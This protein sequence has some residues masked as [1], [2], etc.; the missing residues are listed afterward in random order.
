MLRSL[1]LCALLLPEM[2]FCDDFSAF[3]RGFG[4]FVALSAPHVGVVEKNALSVGI[5]RGCEGR[6]DV[7]SYFAAICFHETTLKVRKYH[8]VPQGTDYAGGHYR[9]IFA[10]LQR[11]GHLDGR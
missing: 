2:A 5:W 6:L 3:Q 4:D 1:L 10:E 11:I 8:D 7:A 9:T